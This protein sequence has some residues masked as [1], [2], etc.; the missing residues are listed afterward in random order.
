MNL[1]RVLSIESDFAIGADADGETLVEPTIAAV[2]VQQDL[3][4]VVEFL[5]FLHVELI[6]LFVQR[7]DKS[8]R[9]DGVQGDVVDAS[10]EERVACLGPFR[11]IPGSQSGQVLLANG[12]R[13]FRA[14]D[15]FH[16]T[17]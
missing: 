17:E 12:W 10:G 5:G 4:E 15:L 16:L 11:T 7:Q 14:Q 8:R 6:G 13:R 1:P 3:A 2:A 9:F